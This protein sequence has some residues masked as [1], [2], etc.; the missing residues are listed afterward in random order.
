MWRL[1][2]LLTLLSCDTELATPD[3]G[4]CADE[5]APNRW[6]WFVAGVPVIEDTGFSESLVPPDF[7]LMDQY[8]EP[9]CLW[10][11]AGK[12][13]VL[14][15]SA[16]WCGPCREVAKHVACLQKKYGDD[17]VYATLITENSFYE[18]AEMKDVQSWSEEYGLNAEGAQTPV[19][20]D[21]SELFASPTWVPSLPAFLVLDRDLKIVY[22]GAGVEG[23]RLVQE[24]LKELLGEPTGSCEE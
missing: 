3:P 12:V 8:G 9:T 17:L 6:P 7:R 15:A 11:W 24:K 22:A 4:T 19:L 23:D 10:P 2:T 18:P 21:G 20:L 16:L 13:V 5:T 1:L 14:D